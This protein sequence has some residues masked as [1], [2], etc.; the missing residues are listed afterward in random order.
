V[1][2]TPSLMVFYVALSRYYSA[3]NRGKREDREEV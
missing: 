3:I 1:P 2:M